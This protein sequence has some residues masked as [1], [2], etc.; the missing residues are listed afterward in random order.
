[1]VT[2]ELALFDAVKVIP[3]LAILAVAARQDWRT[4][5]ASNKLWLYAPF[6]FVLTVVEVAYVP[7]LLVPVVVSGLFASVLG[8]VLFGLGKWGGAD[9]KAVLTL[10]VCVPVTFYMGNLT[11]LPLQALIIG[12]ALAVVYSVVS[13]RKGIRFLPFLFIGVMISLIVG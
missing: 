13:K 6:G 11:L 10:S 8:L 7:L 12:Q 3:V 4:G 5:E 1:M 2:F 9:A